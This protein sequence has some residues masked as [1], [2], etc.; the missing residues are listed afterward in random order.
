MGNGPFADRNM[1]V[2]KEREILNKKNGS[3]TKLRAGNVCLKRLMVNKRWG[4]IDQDK[5]LSKRMMQSILKRLLAFIDGA[6]GGHPKRVTS[7]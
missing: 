7:I 6:A 3:D 5:R 2:F 1:K 4:E